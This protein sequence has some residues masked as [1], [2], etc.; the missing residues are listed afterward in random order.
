MHVPRYRRLPFCHLRKT[1]P[2]LADF[3]FVSFSLCINS[4]KSSHKLVQVLGTES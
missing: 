1:H 2:H 3:L 4:I